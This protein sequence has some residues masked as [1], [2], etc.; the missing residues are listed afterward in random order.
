MKK[1]LP[2]AVSSVLLILVTFVEFVTILRTNFGMFVYTLD[3]TY[4]HLSVAENIGRG[5]YGINP[6]EF[7]S[8][9]SSIIWPFLLAPFTYFSFGLYIPLLLNI[10]F[11]I[12]TLYVLWKIF[13]RVFNFVK[14]KDLLVSILLVLMIPATAMVGLIFTGMEHSLQVFSIV[15]ILYAIIQELHG[16]FDARIMIS[17]VVLASIVRYEN[18]SVCLFAAAFF[19]VRGRKKQALLSMVIVIA[20]LLLFSLFIYLNEGSFLPSSVMA[21]MSAMRSSALNFSK[22]FEVTRS[23]FGMLYVAAVFVIILIAVVQRNDI[24]AVVLAAGAVF[25]TLLHLSYGKTQ[26]YGSLF[27]DFGY[28][29]RYE[30]YLWT[31][32]LTVTI[33]LS[34]TFLVTLF[35]YSKS[36]FIVLLTVT[37][38]VFCGRANVMLFSIPL[39]SNN[40]FEQHVQIHDFVARFYRKPVAVHD[41]GCVSY[42]NNNYVLDLWGL[43]SKKVFNIRKS[44]AGKSEWLDS[45]VTAKNISLVI[46][47][48]VWFP[49][50]PAHWTKIAELTLTK[51]EI[52]ASENVVSFYAVNNTE[53]TVQ[54][55]RAF[56]NEV[57]LKE[58]LRILN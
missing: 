4:I 23:S 34:R 51:P 47:Y 11:Q 58:M 2:F 53:E 29:F 46:I 35:N 14:Q 25:I 5:S 7:A 33:I 26:Y 38:I 13:D 54:K 44:N 55:L 48:D 45:L 32:L 37:E 19:F 18:L 56:R 30:M 40:V 49:R 10:F 39:A 52:T 24:T 36:L 15:L 3:D 57:P 17:S 20:S 8:A 50:H 28:Y 27:M 6:G 12:G 22:I 1:Y 43:T 9:A 21:K 41:I 31:F 42:N 16:E